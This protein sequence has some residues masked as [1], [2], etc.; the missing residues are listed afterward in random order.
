MKR[1]SSST[2]NLIEGGRA[3]AASTSQQR[4]QQQQQTCDKTSTKQYAPK[5]QQQQVQQQPVSARTSTSSRSTT[6]TSTA[7]ANSK[8]HEAAHIEADA[9][10]KLECVLADPMVAMA[11]QRRPSLADQQSINVEQQGEFR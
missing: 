3:R 11:R 2:I 1:F 5:Q 6:A 4:H 9:A 7:K 10:A 8:R